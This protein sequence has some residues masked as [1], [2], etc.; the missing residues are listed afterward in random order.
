M[1]AARQFLRHG[2]CHHVAQ[3]VGQRLARV[4]DH[5][6]S[7]GADIG[8]ADALAMLGDFDQALRYYDRARQRA[9]NRGFE[10]VLALVDESVALVDLARGRYREALAG[11]ESARRRYEALAMPQYLAVAEKQLA[12]A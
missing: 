2:A 10:T 9:G 7:I 6:H 8:L 3:R 12:D 1:A 4:G 5:E 11:L